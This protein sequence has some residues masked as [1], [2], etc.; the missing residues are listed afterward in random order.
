[1]YS[2]LDTNENILPL[3][4]IFPF[5]I[6]VYNLI[7]IILWKVPFP[8][9]GFFRIQIWID[10]QF[11]QLLRKP[12]CRSFAWMCYF[13]VVGVKKMGLGFKRMSSLCSNL[14]LTF[15][16]VWLRMSPLFSLSIIFLLYK[17]NP[18]PRVIYSLNPVYSRVTGRLG[19]LFQN[20]RII[21]PIYQQ[22]RFL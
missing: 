8:P 15:N 6:L 5:W 20:K 10:G 1:M 2:L 18:L 7:E 4:Y 21:I 11:Q 14:V 3:E 16:T 13:C 19:A 17:W 9:G 22:E 12:C